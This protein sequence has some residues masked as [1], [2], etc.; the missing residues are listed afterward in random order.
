VIA[1]LGSDSSHD[2]LARTLRRIGA[3]ESS[4]EHQ[5]RPF[6]VGTWH[7]L[8]DAGAF[9]IVAAGGSPADVV[10]AVEALGAEAVAGPVAGA[11]LVAELPDDLGTDVTR[12][13]ALP[14]VADGDSVIPWG[15]DA[16]SIW[17]LD[18]P[19]ASVAPAAWVGQ[20]AEVR[21]LAGDRWARGEVTTTGAAVAAADAICLAD[22]AAGAYAIGA[23]GRS[24]AATIEYTAAREQ[25]GQ[26]LL[27][28]QAVAHRLAAADS[29]LE[30]AAALVRMV[31]SVSPVDQALAAA[32]RRRA[33]DV[34]VSVTLIAQHLH[35]ALGFVDGT[36]ISTLSRRVQQLM[37][38][39][40]GR[41][42]NTEL[43]LSL[44]T[45]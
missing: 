11:V 15:F 38:D 36:L 17:L 16:T 25:F 40:P 24:L 41:P 18:A 34:A 30:A 20:I 35:G 19:S 5:S 29:E 23:A 2:D 7:R 21:S 9:G 3:G 28:F 12:G 43:V 31:A 13:V 14:A 33:I 32:A 1:R 10:A 39:V 8:A 44:A 4:G 42:A 45:G 22:L 26:P 6:D 37:H 27:R